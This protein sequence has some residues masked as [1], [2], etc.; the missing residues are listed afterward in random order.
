MVTTRN[1][2][3]MIVIVVSMRPQLLAAPVFGPTRP[4]RDPHHKAGCATTPSTQ[5]GPWKHMVV[6]NGHMGIQRCCNGNRYD[7][8]V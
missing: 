3:V 7:L 4:A 1:N 2:S 8:G 6:L 5:R